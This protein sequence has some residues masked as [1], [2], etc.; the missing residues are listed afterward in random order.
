[1]LVCVSIYLP[2]GNVGEGAMGILRVSCQNILH[3]V[4]SS[5]LGAGRFRVDPGEFDLL[6]FPQC[7]YLTR[8]VR[9]P[10]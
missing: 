6:V 3:L 4:L 10:L 9:A 7:L 8:W 5:R 2:G 1:M